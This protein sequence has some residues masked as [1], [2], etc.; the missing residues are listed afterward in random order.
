M[1]E[2]RIYLYPGLGPG[3]R[4]YF[5]QRGTQEDLSRLGLKLTEGMRMSFWADDADDSDPTDEMMFEGTVHLDPEFGRW[6][7]PIDWNSFRHAS[8]AGEE[9]E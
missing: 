3:E 9:S 7:A 1:S 4:H 6:Y 8:E 2:R 5:D